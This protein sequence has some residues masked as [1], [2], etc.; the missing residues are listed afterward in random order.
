MTAEP[1]LYAVVDI[2]TTGGRPSDTRIME[3]AICITDGQTILSEYTQLV[4]PKRRIDHYVR[5]LTGITEDLVANEPTWEQI[6][7]HVH[8]LLDNKIFVAHNVDFDHSIVRRQ[9][10]EIGQA[11]EVHKICTVKASRTAFPGLSSYSLGNIT[12]HLDIPLEQAHRALE[13]ARA[14]AELLHKILNQSDTI[15]FEHELRSQNYVIDLPDHW[16]IRN[17]QSIEAKPGLIYYHDTDGHIIRIDGSSNLRKSIFQFLTK[18]VPRDKTSAAIADITSTLTLDYT[19][20]AFK[21]EIKMLNDIQ[22]LRPRYN[23]SMKPTSQNFTLK[24]EADE[25]GLYSLQIAKKTPVAEELQGIIIY[26]SSQKSAEKIKH[27][28]MHSPDCARL[29]AIR[30]RCMESQDQIRQIYVKEHNDL[31]LSKLFKEFCCPIEH[32]YYAFHIR[33]DHSAEVIHVIN[34]YISSWGSGQLENKQLVN[35]QKEF[36]LDKD[37][38]F[39]R[40]F[41]N[42]LPKTSYMLIKDNIQRID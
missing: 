2:E 21:A 5:K 26:A 18:D 13:D 25:H 1:I 34:H 27:K 14:T 20:D 3:I 10:L 7:E 15:D 16:S 9:F 17:D 42:I 11:L 33:N 36:E 35:Y 40:K 8:G 4:N 29:P 38:K 24:I 41:L 12:A 31:L 37:Q 30:K 32:G 39:T 19:D 6:A 23:K 28:I 22:A